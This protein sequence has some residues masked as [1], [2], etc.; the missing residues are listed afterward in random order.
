MK[1]REEHIKANHP[2]VY[3]TIMANLEKLVTDPNMVIEDIKQTGT[4]CA[5]LN[6]EN[7][8]IR[9]V[10]KLSTTKDAIG[11]KNSIITGQFIQKNT[12]RQI[13]KKNEICGSLQKREM[14][15]N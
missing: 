15:L 1:E 8:M 5:L 6:I 11:Y 9:L 13:C 4:R 14:M 10:V 3:E 2:E 12:Y 7:S